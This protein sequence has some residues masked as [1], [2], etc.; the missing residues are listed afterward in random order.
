MSC[1]RLHEPGEAFH[2]HPPGELHHGDAPGDGAPGG[3]LD[4]VEAAPKP[5]GWVQRA[6]SLTGTAAAGAWHQHGYLV[7]PFAAIPAMECSELVISHAFSAPLPALAAAGVVTVLGEGVTEV[8][9]WRGH[10]VR[11]VRARTRAAV[12]AGGAMAAV[13]GAG[14]FNEWTALATL[15]VG[16]LA[17]G[18]ITYE[19]HKAHG[20]RPRRPAAVAAGEPPA[21]TAGPDP[22]LL[23]FTAEFCHPDGPLAGVTAS[24]F[25]ELP[26]GFMLELSFA[27]TRH[28]PADVKA[29]EVPIAKLYG[30]RR[31]GVSVD[32]VPDP[33]KDNENFCQVVIRKLPVLATGERAKPVLRCWDGRSTWNPATG[34]FDL[35][36]FTD[37][38]VTHYQA[39]KPHSG[40]CMGMFSGTPGSGKTVS[41]HVA[42]A[43]AG[44]AVL[45]SRC[46]RAGNVYSPGLCERCDMHRVMA[47]W[48]G[49]AQAQGMGVW[50][51][52]ADL[53]GWGPEGCVELLE[54]TNEVYEARGPQMAG[55]EWWDEGPDGRRRHNR[56]K[57]WFD[58]E[59]GFPLIDVTI[60]E[61]PL[62]VTH[63]DPEVRKTGTRLMV[64][65]VTLW[66]KRGI[67]PKIGT[68][69][70]DTTLT[71]TREIR[72]MMKFFNSVAHRADE[73]SSNMGGIKNDP[74][75]LNPDIPG[76][77]YISGFDRR[78]SEFATK[79][80]PEVRHPGD[81]ALTDI[82]HVA[83]IIG[84]TPVR[85]DEAT[86]SVMKAWNLAHQTVFEEWTGH[87]DR[88]NGSA[89][90]YTGLAAVPSPVTP[91]GA[92]MAY[93][94]DAEKVRNC[95]LR[96][97]GPW[98]YPDLMRETG[99][100]LGAVKASA[101]ALEA[102][103]QAVLG[104]KQLQAA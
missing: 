98:T 19:E 8:V 31:D 68:Q 64:R 38:T 80:A 40:A 100:S 20:N 10:A 70:L 96:R 41:L 23:Q 76:A 102:N 37:G 90:P 84:Q 9:N 71:G 103:G 12:A 86:L 61:W 69:V 93:W 67:K 81:P 15:I 47:V 83:G 50:M 30:V 49:D 89:A 17:A 79:Y 72:E 66:R 1:G 91:P 58:V 25:R 21:I 54:F 32:Y 88:V 75:L 73:V 26:S 59:I 36:W 7:K 60:D 6:L 95:L 92:G 104:D 28:S 34:T 29:L 2:L 97:P 14:V 65:A 43:E 22:R 24:G 27:R 48:M 56:G 57:G 78:D 85:Y 44:L 35:G 11:P 33:E 63:T 101:V 18:R 55:L 87:P 42:A 13:G 39:H 99:L 51:G 52:R 82:R 16:A 53:G 4:A 45:C 62:I 74:R 94:E 3:E 5:P 77:G 46:G